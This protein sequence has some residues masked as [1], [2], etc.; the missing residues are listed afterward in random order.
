[1]K[2][3]I[4]AI[5][6]AV[7]L[8]AGAALAAQGA[9]AQQRIVVPLS[10][11]AQPATLEVNL[12]RGDI[13]V[14]AYD[15][16]E[17]V[18]VTTEGDEDESV[19][20]PEFEEEFEFEPG[21]GEEE[22][23]DD[24]VA[25]V[26]RPSREGLRQIRNNA[27]GVTAEENANTVAVTTDWGHNSVDLEIS[28][29]RRTSVRVNMHQG[30]DLAVSGVVGDHE[31]MN[32]QGDIGGSAVINT[33]NGDIVASLTELTPGMPMSFTSFNG[34]I[35]VALPATLSATLVIN[36]GHGDIFSDFDFTAQ[37]ATPVVESSPDGR[38]RHFRLESAMRAVVGG[39]GPEVRFQTFNGDVVV[40]RR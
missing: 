30:D 22:E 13:T 9:G 39:G 8:A 23:E 31:L 36:A 11:P 10:D 2:S 34:D 24:D 38:N 28:V 20:G 12:G 4:Q 26:Q 19:F 32:M 21:F 40:R 1:M 35:D 5:P 6:A 25:G 18:I 17:I 33:A 37:P 14:T 15:G 27:I 3:T 29:P 7:I 16:S